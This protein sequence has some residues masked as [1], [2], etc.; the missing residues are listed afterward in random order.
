MQGRSRTRERAVRILLSA[1]LDSDLTTTELS[2]IAQELS[3]SPT[4]SW[5][6]GALLRDVLSKLDIPPTKKPVSRIRD[7]LDTVA[8]SMVSRR[9]LSKQTVLELMSTAKGKQQTELG[10]P[11]QTM[12][13]LLKEFLSTASTKERRKFMEMVENSGKEDPYLQGITRRR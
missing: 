2:E 13:E 9:R 4:L 12:R 8:Y 11:N 3:E 7:T 5:D 10:N 6:L 1:L